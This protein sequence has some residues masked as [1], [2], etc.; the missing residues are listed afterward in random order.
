MVIPLGK[1]NV[2][3]ERKTGK[4]RKRSGLEICSFSHLKITAAQKLKKLYRLKYETKTKEKAQDI[5][6]RVSVKKS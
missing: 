5:D 2:K 1:K 3:V 6:L 4:S